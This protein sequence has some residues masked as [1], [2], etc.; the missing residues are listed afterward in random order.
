MGQASYT[1]LFVFQT[2]L[3]PKSL[4]CGIDPVPNRDDELRHAEKKIAA[5]LRCTSPKTEAELT[6][7]TGV[8]VKDRGISIRYGQIK[9]SKQDIQVFYDYSVKMYLHRK[10]GSGPM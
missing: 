3:I 2:T 9:E 4:G 8:V 10:P 5:L 7:L 1:S 6:T